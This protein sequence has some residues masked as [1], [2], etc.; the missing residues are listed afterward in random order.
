MP[1]ITIYDNQ[2]KRSFEHADVNTIIALLN[3]PVNYK[4]IDQNINQPDNIA[5]FVMF[6][7]PFE[8]VINV[9]NLL[10]IENANSVLSTEDFR[11]YP[12]KQ[13]E[14]LE[15]GWE[16]LEGLPEGQKKV[17]GLN[18]GKYTGN[19]W[20]GKY[21]RAPDIYF[22][23]LE[24]GKDKLI[25]LKDIANIKTGV[26]ESG[27]KSYIQ[28]REKLIKAGIKDFSKFLPILKEVK[29]HNKVLI[30]NN[31]SF[32]VQDIRKFKKI[33]KN[34]VAPVLWLS[35][36]GSTHKCQENVNLYPF[37]GNYIGII[38][39]KPI[40]KDLMLTLLNSTLVIF[41]SEILNRGKGIGGGASVVTKSDI[42]KL[43]ILNIENVPQH[44]INRFTNIKNKMNQRYYKS[45]FAELGINPKQPIREQEPNPLPDRKELDDIVFDALALTKEE[46]KEVYWAVAELV[47]N[48]LEKAR[49]V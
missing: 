41:I 7:K 6:K 38:P 30:Y 24:K 23:I 45:I 3:A 40:N 36:R 4:K 33:I 27:Y 42:E 49:S 1:N 32:I 16:Y 29:E 17:D 9:E 48:R 8:E 13:I 44:I 26:K 46:R 18:V 12:K 11:V 34:K 28:S 47:K 15:E 25:K 39:L 5:K 20:G 14:L 10:K 2:A 43:L 19:K 37:S 22:T 35:G 21:L 31:D